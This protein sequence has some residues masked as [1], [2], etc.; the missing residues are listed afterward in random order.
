[1]RKDTEGVKVDRCPKRSRMHREAHNKGAH[2]D[3]THEP[4]IRQFLYFAIVANIM[5]L[6]YFVI[7][8]IIIAVKSWVRSTAPCTC[9]FNILYLF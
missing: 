8:I 3:T 2:C 7:S 5:L 4:G 1:V 6:L 9:F